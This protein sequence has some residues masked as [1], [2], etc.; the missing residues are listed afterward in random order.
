MISRFQ[1]DEGKKRL[2]TVLHAQQIVQDEEPLAAELADAVQLIQ[3]EPGTPASEMIKQGG[4]DNEIYLI[5]TGLVSIRINGR[6]VATRSSGTH[7]G[8]MALIDPAAR[9]NATVIVTQSTLFGRIA[10]PIFS[11]IAQRHPQLWR[12]LALELANRL[13]QRSA[14]VPVPNDKPF[15]FIGSSRRKP[16]HSARDPVWGLP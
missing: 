4:T 5:I 13:R 7:V 8:E 2:I 11:A 12:R 10:E 9:R 14:L 15:L 1:G 6:E 16:A 3:V